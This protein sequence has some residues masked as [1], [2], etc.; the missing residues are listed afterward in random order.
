ML[1][2]PV[3]KNRFPELIRFLS[4]RSGKFAGKCRPM[5]KASK[6]SPN[7]WSYS[8]KTENKPDPIFRLSF[9]FNMRKTCMLF[10]FPE[11]SF[12]C[13]CT[14]SEP[15]EFTRI[16]F[17]SLESNVTC[18]SFWSTRL[19]TAAG[20]QSVYDWRLILKN[21]PPSCDVPQTGMPRAAHASFFLSPTPPPAL[22][23]GKIVFPI[24][25]TAKPGS[26]KRFAGSGARKRELI[27]PL[28]I[29]S[30]PEG[31]ITPF[32]LLGDRCVSFS[33]W[34]LSVLPFRVLPGK[35][36]DEYS[37]LFLGENMNY[38]SFSWVW[39]TRENVFGKNSSE[40]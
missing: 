23:P 33:V 10:H 9:R 15:Y 27:P 32:S 8:R 16:F 4:E 13:K 37:P 2:Y 12:A 34:R 6:P 20:L 22:R 31:F 18:L 14:R 5:G 25:Q 28:L 24:V 7:R 30:P 35:I 17:S 36:K 19:L 1:V 11:V 40:I 26:A 3:R 39:L 38:H 29:F 21:F